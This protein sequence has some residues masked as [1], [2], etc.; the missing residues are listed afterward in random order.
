MIQALYEHIRMQ[1]DAKENM[2]Y[3][4]E[5]KH[6]VWSLKPEEDMQGLTCITLSEKVM[7][8]RTTFTTSDGKPVTFEGLP[9]AKEAYAYLMMRN[10][11]DYRS[12]WMIDFMDDT[13][14]MTYAVSFSDLFLIE[15]KSV[16][17][18]LSSVR[19]SV[20]IAAKALK[21]AR[22]GSVPDDPVMLLRSLKEQKGFVVV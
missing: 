15:T 1:C 2:R 6:I 16:E 5:N 11:F 18:A 8:F 10:A 12:V 21:T 22:T 9:Y 3:D 17:E 7:L 19:K 20:S 14:H 4:A 13:V